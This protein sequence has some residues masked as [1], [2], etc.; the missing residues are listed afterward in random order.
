VAQLSVTSG[1]QGLRQLQQ[2]LA[3]ENL[4][5]TGDDG[6]M[7]PLLAQSWTRSADG[8]VV[9]VKLR[10]HVKFHDGSPMDPETVAA[11]LPTALQG[12]L[13]PVFKDVG[14]VRPVGSDSIA[15]GF[16]EASPF[17]IEALEAPVQKPGPGITGTGP[18][19]VVPGSTKQMA[20]NSSYDLGKPAISEIHVQTYPSIRTAWAEMLRNQLDMLWEVGPEA[21]DSIKGSSTISVF[22]FTRRYQHIIVFNPDAKILA[23]PEVRRAL[24]FAIDRPAV[25]RAALNDFGLASS[26]P[27]WPRHWAVQGSLAKF[28]FDPKRAAEMLAHARR[29]AS[30]LRFTCLVSADSIDERIALE[31][32][33]QL[34]GVGVEMAV[35]EA[36]REEIMQRGAKHQFEAA[37]IEVISGPT[38]VRP[39]VMWHSNTPM[40]WGAFGNATTEAALDRVRHAVTDESYRSAAV[41]LQD[42]FI[43]N[44]PAIFL[45]WSQRARAV[46][47]RFMIPTTEPGRDII[48]NTWLWKGV[49]APEQ[50]SRN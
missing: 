16:P 2:L 3:V 45:A 31:V 9:T 30:P 32:K 38:L 7:Q 27:V 41:G 28:D 49:P 50:A 5:R 11:L 12:L 42:A 22:T 48:G 34:A 36:S 8:R 43:A 6:R 37:V 39:Y 26:G 21:V 47:K 14:Y 1:T 24:N 23:S 46:S 29:D 35:E 17:L 10:P 25:V 44:P 4:M 15:I 40:N 20:A 19:A 13:G 33:R 18:F